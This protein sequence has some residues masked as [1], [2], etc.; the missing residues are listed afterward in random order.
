VL[1][2]RGFLQPSLEAEVPPKYLS[3]LSQMLRRP[4]EETGPELLVALC[5]QIALMSQIEMNRDQLIKDKVL[6]PLIDLLRSDDDVLLLS[7]AKALVNLSS[8]N[9]IAKDS[10]VNEGGV[11]AV[12]PHLLNK[13]HELTRAFSFYSRIV[14]PRPSFEN[15]S[16]T[17]APSPHWSGS[18]TRRRSR[19]HSGATLSSPPPLP[20]SG[21]LWLSR[22]PRTWSSRRERWR[23]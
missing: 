2:E 1:L 21:T 3:F 19:T 10:I 4:F 9:L 5:N 20:P 15:A 6:V 14:S 11:R 22:A 12:I 8:S 7:V 23:R 16:S 17:T 13:P 18:C